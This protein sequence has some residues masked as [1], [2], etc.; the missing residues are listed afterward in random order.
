MELLHRGN[1]NRTVE[2]TRRAPCPLQQGGRWGRVLQ[3]GRLPGA[4]A[5]A[6]D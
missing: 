4:C 1:Q 2:P 3:E 5:G 6:S